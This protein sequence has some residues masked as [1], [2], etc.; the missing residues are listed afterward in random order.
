MV[1]SGTAGQ[2]AARMGMFEVQPALASG[3]KA[4][5]KN[6]FGQYL[7]YW[8]EDTEWHIGHDYKKALAGVSSTSNT[9]N[10]PQ[11]SSGWIEYVD[12]SWKASNITV[13]AGS[14][15]CRLAVL[16]T[17]ALFATPVGRRWMCIHRSG[18]FPAFSCYGPGIR[19]GGAVV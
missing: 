12:G 5:Y 9:H 1:V 7:Y 10:C 16:P 18:F 6:F 3:G 4:V 2:Q 13:V 8:P 15:A 11:D 17:R 19:C 14:C